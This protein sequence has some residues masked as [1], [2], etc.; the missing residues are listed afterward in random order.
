MILL[1]STIH[2]AVPAAGVATVWRA[3]ANN[4]SV[5]IGGSVLAFF[6][7]VSLL[8]PCSASRPT[9]L[10][11]TNINRRPGVSSAVTL[12]N[13]ESVQRNFWMGTDGLGRDIYSARVA[14]GG[15]VSLVIGVRWRP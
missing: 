9:R 12:A 6:A 7:L 4:W 5:R 13:G 10:D 3:L 14:C 15:Q 8:A 11:S 1:D 2:T